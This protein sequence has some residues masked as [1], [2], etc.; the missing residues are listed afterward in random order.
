MCPLPEGRNVASACTL[1]G[2]ASG[3]GQN[4]TLTGS[5]GVGININKMTVGSMDHAHPTLSVKKKEKKGGTVTNYQAE[6][7]RPDAPQAG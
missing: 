2:R 5:A 3:Y 7:T 6:K 1:L 4:G